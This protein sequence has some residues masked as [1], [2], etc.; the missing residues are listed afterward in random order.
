MMMLMSARAVEKDLDLTSHVPAG[1]HG[2]VIGDAGRLRQVLLNLIGNAIKFTDHGSVSLSV[3]P[4][5]ETDD[6]LTLKFAVADTGIGVPEED[7]DKLFTEF[8]QVD[9]S[10]SRRFGGTGLGLAICRRI[11]EAMGGTVGVDSRPGEGSTFWFTVTLPK[12]D[13]ERAATPRAA[14]TATANVP[15]LKVLLVEDNEINQKVA[16]GL[17]ARDSHK[18]TLAVTGIEAVA[19]VARESFDL[20]LMDVQLPEMDGMEATRRI[21]QMDDRAKASVPIVALTANAMPGDVK[22]CL[23]AGMNDVIAK[24]VDPERL[25]KAILDVAHLPDLP[26]PAPARAARPAA[27]PAA[28]G[29]AAGIDWPMLQ[30]LRDTI[31]ADKLDELFGL[32][33]TSWQSTIAEMWT[34]LDAGDLDGLRQLAHRI[35]GG[36]LNLGLNS[37]AGGR[38]RHRRR[39]PRRRHNLDPAAN[40]DG[41]RRGLSRNPDGARPDDV[42]NSRRTAELEQLRL[43]Q[44][45]PL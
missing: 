40:G 5:A 17:L 14:R 29:R 28:A 35:K 42:A 31:G 24:P 18:V 15:P 43:P 8:Y 16:M 7:R 26:V 12:G 1:M 19:A 33:R 25:V 2:A 41:P 23:D 39:D 11:V 36:A 34:A 21:R 13:P 4:L 3:E 38:H 20:V 10:I 27:K 32:F 37:V 44:P 45:V 9:P 6:M 22:M 30:G